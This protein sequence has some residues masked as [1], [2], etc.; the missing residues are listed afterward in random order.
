MISLSDE[1]TEMLRAATATMSVGE[2]H[3]FLTDFGAAH[4]REKFLS[5]IRASAVEA[6]GFLVIDA[7]H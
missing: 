4:T 1:Q 7:L 6:V 5:A 3:Q 2:Q